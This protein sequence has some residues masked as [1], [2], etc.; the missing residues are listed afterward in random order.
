MSAEQ[1]FLIAI[2]EYRFVFYMLATPSCT[3]D[4]RT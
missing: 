3:S 4:T 1:D 2:C